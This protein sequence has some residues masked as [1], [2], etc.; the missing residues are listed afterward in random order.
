MTTLNISD[1]ASAPHRVTGYVGLWRWWTYTRS[2][3]I[4]NICED[5]LERLESLPTSQGHILRHQTQRVT[6]TT[7]Q[8]DFI[9]KMND[10]CMHSVC[11][12]LVATT[13]NIC[14]L[15]DKVE[16]HMPSAKTLNLI[17]VDD[18]VKHSTYAPTQLPK[19]LPRFSKTTL[20]TQSFCTPTSCVSSDSCWRRR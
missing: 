6:E 1:S 16:F 13:F 7:Y 18:D 17:V 14:G 11:H 10:N 15:S 5:R 12:K 9:I 8:P 20:G 4:W 19:S 3:T 2:A